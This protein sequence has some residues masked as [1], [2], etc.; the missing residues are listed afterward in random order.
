MHVPAHSIEELIQASPHQVLFETLDHWIQLTFPALDRRLIQ[1]GT[2]TFIGYGE[3]AT[4]KEGDVYDS[5]IA[6]A[7]QKHYLSC[8]FAGEK[9]GEPILRSYQA[10]FAT[11]TVGK[12]CLRL[13]NSHTIDFAILG[14]MI[15]DSIAWNE[16]QET[17]AKS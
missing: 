9:A 10:H 13:K 5:L 12:V 6:L 16:S 15:K 7:P 8:Y 2:M 17:N 1:S 14:A 11:S 3:L 4:A